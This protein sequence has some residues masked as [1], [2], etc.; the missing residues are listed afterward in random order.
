MV[1]IRADVVIED[2]ITTYIITIYIITIEGIESHFMF[3]FK[4]WKLATKE[5]F[6]PP[7]TTSTLGG[8][9][10]QIKNHKYR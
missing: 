1:T 7:N 4:A 5:V 2:V 10:K 6:L 9:R 8:E 3:L